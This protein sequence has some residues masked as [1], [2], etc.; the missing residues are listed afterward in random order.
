MSEDWQPIETAPKDRRLLLWDGHDMLIG[1]W[2]VSPSPYCFAGWTT[3]WETASGYDVGYAPISPT[4][5][6]PLPEPPP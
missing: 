2:G 1:F 5:W 6:Q 3:G 4:H